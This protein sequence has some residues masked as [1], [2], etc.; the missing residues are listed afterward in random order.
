MMCEKRDRS[1]S[2]RGA[3]PMRKL[4]PLL[5]M[6]FISTFA[7]EG[8]I[9]HIITPRGGSE[10]LKENKALVKDYYDAFSKND[11][12]ALD[13]LL[14]SG[15]GVQDSNLIFDTEYSKYDAFSKNL[16][17]RMRSLHEALPEFNLT[18][19]EMMAEGN[20]V[21]VRIQI[22]GIQKGAFLGVEPTNKPVVIKT[23]ALF[24]LD[25][26]KITHLNEVWNKLE[27]MKQIGFIIL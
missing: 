26:G 20:K 10:P 21:L 12:S 1:A 19:I 11:S 8:E 5:L 15:Y 2:D 27:V 9:S 17:V 7:G 25:G 18:I 3:H 6:L 23:F 4:I 13:D 24:T 16:A 22:Q 14:A